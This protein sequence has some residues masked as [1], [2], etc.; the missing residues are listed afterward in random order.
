M[1]QRQL[2]RLGIGPPSGALRLRILQLPPLRA[3]LIWDN[4]SGHYSESIV[5]WLL[6]QGVLPLYTPLSGSWLNM[7]EPR[8]SH[9]RDAA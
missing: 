7:T 3:I 5:S 2:R 8:P 4:L 6:A 1:T 9:Y